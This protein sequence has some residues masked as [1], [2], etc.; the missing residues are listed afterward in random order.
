MLDYKII[1]KIRKHL[2]ICDYHMK[3]GTKLW[4]QMSRKLSF[5]KLINLCLL[6]EL[7]VKVM[8]SEKKLLE[9]TYYVLMPNNWTTIKSEIQ[10]QIRR[11][12]FQ[13][14]NIN[15]RKYLCGYNNGNNNN[16]FQIIPLEN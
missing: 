4:N 14:Y 11:K 12:I 9:N 3:F 1:K 8:L 2:L 5:N 16:E 15:F 10:Y 7:D 6:I 13:D